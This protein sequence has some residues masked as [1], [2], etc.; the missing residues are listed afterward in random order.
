MLVLS[1]FLFCIF[2]WCDMA[3][4]V[5]WD[6][7]PAELRRPHV[8]KRTVTEKI[9]HLELIVVHHPARRIGIALSV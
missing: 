3:I 4:V 5:R 8:A 7:L 6:R 1:V 2:V 9:L